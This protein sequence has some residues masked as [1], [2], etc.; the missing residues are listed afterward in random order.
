[1]ATAA[2]LKRYTP[3]EYLAL[4]RKAEYKSEYW[5][6]YITAMSGASRKH[7]LIAANTLAE[8]HTRLKGRPC[9]VYGSDMRIRTSPGGLYTYP[10]IS[11]VCGPPL[12]LDAEVDTLLNPMLIVEVLSRST[13]AYDRGAK[14]ERYKSIESLREYV[15]IA[16]DEVLVERFVKRGDEWVHLEIR[17][18]DATL[19]LESIRCAIP[20][21]EVYARVVLPDATANGA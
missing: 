16:Q 2:T 9:E 21:R 13:E 5:G 20:M 12:F 7:N 3:E 8:V 4:E 6:G 1:M 14:F 11:A 18:I 15:I 10:D 19:E 17:D